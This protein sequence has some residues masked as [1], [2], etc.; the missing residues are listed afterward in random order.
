LALLSVRPQE[1]EQMQQAMKV[2][3]GLHLFSAV[4]VAFWLWLCALVFALFLALG[5]H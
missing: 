3:R 1:Q 5:K 2:R 4:L